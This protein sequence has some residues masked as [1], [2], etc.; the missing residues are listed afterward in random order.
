VGFG[1]EGKQPDEQF[2]ITRLNVDPWFLPTTG[3]KLITGRNFDP[4]ISSDT[5]GG[6][7]VNESAAKRMGWTPD[8]ALGKGF[9]LWGANGSIIGVVEDFHFRPLTSAIEPLVFFCMPNR[10]YGGIMVK[11]GPDRI[12]ETISLIESFY[13]KYEAGTPAHYSFVDQ[14]LEQQYQLEQKTGKIVFFF[15]ALAIFVA[16]LGLYGLATFNTERRTKEIGIRKVMG[17][18]VVNVGALL[19][20]DF[21]YLILLGIIIASPIGYWLMR[22]WLEGFAYRIE[23]SWLHFVVAGLLPLLIAVVTVLYQATIAARLNPVKS[24]RSE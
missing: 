18:S 6:Y 14:Q 15:S 12:T 23:L 9:T 8:E 10:Y 16:C 3:I 20:R 19:S 2:L 7:I 24:L 21:I 4:L 13:K 1:W 5:I 17:A 22:N 11:A